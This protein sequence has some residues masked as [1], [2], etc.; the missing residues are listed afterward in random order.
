MG[1]NKIYSGYRAYQ[2]LEKGVDYKDY[3][4]APEIGRVPGYIVPVRE[5]EEDRV[6]K[7]I[8]SSVVISLHDHPSIYPADL[9]QIS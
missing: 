1:K 5:K 6:Q 8:E 4:L 9:N 3:P 2:Y 7:L